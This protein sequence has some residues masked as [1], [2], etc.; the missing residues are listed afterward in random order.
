MI[1][2]PPIDRYFAITTTDTATNSITSGCSPLLVIDTELPIAPDTL[3]FS[4]TS[5]TNVTSITLSW[6][7]TTAVPDFQNYTVEYFNVAGCAGTPDTSFT[8]VGGTS[9][10][11]TGIDG[12]T[13]S[14]RVVVFELA[15]NQAVSTC[16]TDLNVDTTPPAVATSV[17]WLGGITTSNQLV[18]SASWTGSSDANLASETLTFFNSADC[19]G[20]LVGVADP[21]A[22]TVAGAVVT[23]LASDA[24]TL[25]PNFI[26]CL[27]YTSPSPRD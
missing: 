25:V 15:D 26:S 22:N 9:Q 14:F 10:V 27:L 2:N 1:T 8:G 6:V 12:T 21:A 19:S 20:A 11:V 3:T 4:E 16:S 7:Q 23:H 13:H 5:P 24:P 18:E 17:E